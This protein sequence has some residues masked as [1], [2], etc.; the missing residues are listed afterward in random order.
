MPDAIAAFHWVREHWIASELTVG[1]VATALWTAAGPMYKAYVRW[2]VKRLW[3]EFRASL[4]EARTGHVVPLKIS[5]DEF[6]RTRPRQLRSVLRGLWDRVAEL[7][8]VEKSG[9]SY[10][11]KAKPF[12]KRGY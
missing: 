12:N 1:G 7:Q 11:L 4:E 10:I 3:P 5:F 6:A 8:D 2:Q 9:D